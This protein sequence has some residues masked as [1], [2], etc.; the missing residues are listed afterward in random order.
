MRDKAPRTW[1]EKVILLSQGL[2]VLWVLVSAV[3]WW[4]E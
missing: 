1:D 2:I 4:L 3:T